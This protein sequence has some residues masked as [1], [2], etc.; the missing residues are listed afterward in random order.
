MSPTKPNGS[1]YKG[2]THDQSFKSRQA[3]GIKEDRP[4]HSTAQAWSFFM[5]HA[6]MMFSRLDKCVSHHREIVTSHES[7]G[8]I[9][10]AS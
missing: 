7:V 5:K 10:Q 9:P 1:L 8:I 4:F 3:L 2:Q 6:E